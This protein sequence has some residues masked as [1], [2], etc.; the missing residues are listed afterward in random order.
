MA[1]T[2]AGSKVPS[3]SISMFEEDDEETW[4][5]LVSI[6]VDD[7]DISERL[8]GLGRRLEEDHPEG[9]D[10]D[11]L[12]HSLQSHGFSYS[13]DG[14]KTLK[15]SNPSSS[16]T[17]FPVAFQT[18]LGKK[19]LKATS[20]L[21]KISE[22]RAV[23]V[24]MSALRSVDSN[25]S[26]FQSLLGTRDL[27]M[28]TLMHHFQ[29]RFARLSVLTECLR[30]EQDPETLQRRAIVDF[31][32]SLDSKYRD[33]DRYRGL[34]R[35][36][37]TLACA[38]E[39]DPTR[40]QIEPAKDL[41]YMKTLQ[42]SLLEKGWKT[43]QG[44]LLQEQREQRMRERTEAM[45]ALLLLLYNRIH[46][47]VQ[48]ADYA[49]ILSA[50][51]GTSQF[52]RSYGKQ[53][54]RLC[55]LAGLI[56]AESVSLWRA[57]EPGIDPT[58]GWANKH[59]LLL[60]VLS[61]G[62]N[63]AAE[64]EIQSLKRMLL[65]SA[66]RIPNDQTSGYGD[67][68]EA[69]A[70]LAFGLLLALAHRSILS[71]DAGRD[72]EAYWRNFNVV[73]MEI[74]KTS[75]SQY[76]AFGYMSRIVSELTEETPPTRRV[77]FHD[78][79]Y[80]WQFSPE[81]STPLLLGNQPQ[82]EPAPVTTAYTTILREVLAAL[83]T[84]FED[85]VLVV[86]QPSAAENL[87]LLC[88]VARSIYQNN[89]LLCQQFWSDWEVYI[90]QSTPFG[91]FPI[92][93]LL[94]S[95]HKL[96]VGAFDARNL[97]G[98]ANE[99][100]IPMAAP[101]FYLLS[102][103]SFNSHIVETTL[104]MLPNRMVRETLLSCR[105][106]APLSNRTEAYG[107]SRA[108]VLDSFSKMARVGNSKACK[109]TLRLS[110]EEN[111]GSNGRTDGP[112]VLGRIL[113]ET[114]DVDVANAV[115]RIMAYL[116]DG[117]PQD[118]AVQ[119]TREL[120]SSKDSSGLAGFLIHGNDTTCSVSLVLLELVN[121]LKTVLFCDSLTESDAVVFL[122]GVKEGVL[123][124]GTSLA[125]SLSIAT[126]SLNGR[127]L[128][129]FE[130]AQLILQSF[131]NFL[132]V[133][134][135]I[136]ELHGSSKVRESAIHVR[137]SVIDALTTSTGLGQA[138]AYYTTAPVSLTLAIKLQ[139]A[140]D[141]HS[142]LQQVIN[143]SDSDQTNAE[144]YGAWRSVL[145][146]DKSG[147][148]V[149]TIKEFL[150]DSAGKIKAEELELEGIY[151]RGWTNGSA[152]V[153]P[154]DAAGSALQLLSTWASTVG[155]IVKAHEE[156]SDTHSSFSAQKEIANRSPYSLL[157][158]LASNP[159]PCRSN[160][161]LSIIWEAAG[162]SNFELL[163][164]YLSTMSEETRI[165]PYIPIST[166]LD[167]L[168]ACLIHV[169]VAC[170]KEMLADSMLFRFVYR[171]SRFSQLLIDSIRRTLSLSKKGGLKEAE[172]REVLNGLFSLRVLST[173]VEAS[174]TIACS[175][176]QLETDSI[177]P[178]LTDAACKAGGM[179][180]S[181]QI[182]ENEESVV[183]MRVA[184]G[185][186][187]VIA[188]LWATARS[189]AP[190]DIGGLESQLAKVVDGQMA[191][192]TDLVSIVKKYTNEM[193]LETKLIPS[194]E[195]EFA[196][197][198]M[199]TYVSIAL[200]ILVTELTYNV[201]HGRVG[202]NSALENLLLNDFIR[203][204]R[205]TS[206]EGF[207]FTAES[208]KM[209]TSSELCG[210]G[211]ITQPIKFLKCF[212]TTSTCQMS[213]DFYTRENSFDIFSSVFWLKEVFSTKDG[214]VEDMVTKVAISYQLAACDIQILSSWKRFADALVLFSETSCNNAERLI[215]FAQETLKALHNNI[216]MVNKAQ[217]EIDEEFMRQESIRM[218]TLLAEQF[219]F[220]IEMGAEQSKGVQLLPFRDLLGMLDLLTKTSEMVFACTCSRALH[221]TSFEGIQ[222]RLYNFAFLCLRTRN[223]S[224][225]PFCQTCCSL[226]GPLL[227]SAIVINGMIE[228]VL[229]SSSPH[230]Q[231]LGYRNSIFNSLCRVNGKVLRLL[232][233]LIKA[234]DDKREDA[235]IQ[236]YEQHSLLRCCISLFTA[237]ITRGHGSEFSDTS[238]FKMLSA[239]L[240]DHEVLHLLVQYAVS[241]SSKAASSI[242][243]RN[244]ER[245]N[246]GIVKSVLNLLYAV[247]E[248]ND[249][250]MLSIMPG[251]SLSQLVV[252]NALFVFTATDNANLMDTVS[253]RGHGVFDNKNA[254]QQIVRSSSPLLRT[255]RHEPVQ[256]VWLTAMKI[257]QASLR[258]SSNL[259]NV[260]GNKMIGQRFFDMSI[261]FLCVHR[262]QLFSCLK[263]CCSRLTR[264]ILL[265]ATQILA[266]VAELC[267]RSIR[268]T[269]ISSHGK[270]CEEF[271]IWSK[272]VVA[273]ISK[274]LGASGTSRELFQAL[275]DYE[276]S[277]RGNESDDFGEVTLKP[278]NP[279][280]AEGL[281]SAKHEAVKYSH[282][283]SRCVERITAYDFEAA[284]TVP[285]HLKSLSEDGRQHDSELERNCRLSVTSNFALLME[286][287][288]ANCLSQAISIIWRTHP[289]SFSFHVFTQLEVMQSNVM[290]LVHDGMIIGFRPRG[291]E[292]LMS[293]VNGDSAQ[294]FEKLRFGRVCASDT[295]SRTWKVQMLQRGAA[296]SVEDTIEIVEVQQLAG[297]EDLT[298]RK[299]V[300]KYLPAPNSMTDLDNM[301]NDLSLGN[302]ILA[303]RWCHQSSF[304]HE[305]RAKTGN[306]NGRL[307][308][309]IVALLGA[310]M[311][312]HHEI[313]SQVNLSSDRKSRLDSQIFEMFADKGVWVKD[314]EMENVEPVEYALEGR[315]KGLIH[316]SAWD[317]IQSQTRTNVE[318]FWKEKQEKEKRRREKRALSGGGDI[319]WIS[320]FRRKGFIQKSAFR[321]LA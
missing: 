30:L 121:H 114:K 299:V 77:P 33:G 285:F 221:V 304:G 158:S 190:G 168:H 64:K 153:T 306:S 130:S 100:Y 289:V 274:F 67:A 9:P 94:D 102:S 38:P 36:L 57:F 212:P 150:L 80:D 124:A 175:M 160:G 155:D 232:L 301:G 161:S 83:I 243:S 151:A 89:T 265:E 53:G 51:S 287:A 237:L 11:E 271:V 260:Q 134:K 290:S 309:Q 143:G 59:P 195:S 210:A 120:I 61:P 275:H 145:S 317:A 137:D 109:D 236:V 43:F 78:R 125:S 246:L 291:S 292:Y 298:M 266:L 111:P 97:N 282:Y 21:L 22:F 251:V 240:L 88:N 231:E 48:R 19:H 303:L 52:F 276:S 261:E 76:G 28:K 118:W 172:K 255:R 12:I 220:F 280:L 321:G 277:G 123:S 157:W 128:L 75:D 56:C 147:S 55:K 259:L 91:L 68:P 49:L 254:W 18:D 174:P 46:G 252:R 112:R 31:L 311:A 222:V 196:R 129:S 105:S 20:A 234:Q 242:A 176:L 144:R 103:L 300:A 316:P 264:N 249:P 167:F 159:I 152:Q 126:A 224:S 136:I 138:I 180:S 3:S 74:A 247:A 253:L 238:Y 313:G 278:R 23:Q 256:E 29:Q 235:V 82:S 269:F 225:L 166:T 73:G 34:F 218:A 197:C 122:H 203:L 146:R 115:L 233:V 140:I 200:D 132:K 205:L 96:A 307:A 192:I 119:L 226:E 154:V 44:A 86:E 208:S 219:L 165:T 179:L 104:G 4:K 2:T 81:Q 204:E 156:S 63:E 302:L 37:L 223:I 215:N 142:I 5:I 1:L 163:L 95:A 45:E 263:G 170:P 230:P 182:F 72:S 39:Q 13:Q 314:E 293:G 181:D 305:T 60:E 177:V 10:W 92:C 272:Y 135:T 320:N 40:E 284:S 209:F 216:E 117:A 87:G 183:Q 42:E 139:N 85:M 50:F 101:F 229:D 244:N 239:T 228:T 294:D 250:E 24:T 268:E 199:I 70:L 202:S 258:T 279:I 79:P 116:L 267:K 26:Q 90:S 164:P 308:E 141:D 8:E 198:T 315:L 110:L 14:M 54:R 113:S 227:A 281:P 71:S 162:L 7:D 25:G 62:N 66:S 99:S 217:V 47:G 206:F 58:I 248:V 173:C 107:T 283:A 27:L 213:N 207:G 188:L 270:L 318:S 17:S 133:I 184:T 295:V 171:S 106:L 69:L 193:D 201:S 191:F 16:N 245:E 241:A 288:A 211:A 131:T 189:R 214:E 319:N 194:R 32:D 6:K 127:S 273:S 262:E 93:R 310:D 185:C 15:S 65:E 41:H 178:D 148:L 108:I 296:G 187:S 297:I 35:R 286:R 257:L 84:A 98:L 149:A 186:L 169:R 312:I